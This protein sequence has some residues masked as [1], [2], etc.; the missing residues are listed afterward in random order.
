MNI[1]VSLGSAISV[2]G[3]MKNINPYQRE[4]AQ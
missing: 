2:K 1:I 3:E 4:L